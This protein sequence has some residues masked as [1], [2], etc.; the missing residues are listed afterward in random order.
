MPSTS[1]DDWPDSLANHPIIDAINSGALGGV[2][3]S[4][5]HKC[6]Q[7]MVQRQTDLFI[8][9]GSQLRVASLA[10]NFKGHHL[11][12]IIAEALD[13][14]IH[15]LVL[16]PTGNL[17]AVA[18]EYQVALVALPHAATGDASPKDLECQSFQ[19]GAHYHASKV[20]KPI[21]QVSWHP[22]GYEGST[23]LVMTSD[24]S[25]REYNVSDD[26]TTPSQQISF[27]PR[28][29]FAGDEEDRE[30]VSFTIGKSRADWAPLTLY[31]VTRLGDIYSICPYLPQRASV[32]PSYIHSLDSFVFEKREV[33]SRGTSTAAKKLATMYEHQSAYV[34]GLLEQ[35]PRGSKSPSF[36][37]KETVLV[38]PPQNLKKQNPTRQGPFILRPFPSGLEH[39][40]IVNEVTDMT[41]LSLGG[42][43]L[44]EDGEDQFEAENLG[45]LLLAYKDG[46]VDLCLDVDKIEARWEVNSSLRETPM[47]LVY[48][49]IDLGLI[50]KLEGLDSAF[51]SQLE[52]NYPSFYH[53]PIHDGTV[54][55]YHALGVH[56]LDAWPLLDHLRRAL[57][58]NDEATAPIEFETCLRT[59]PPTD[60]VPI[61]TTFSVEKKSSS[62]V[63][64]LAI[65]DD[66][67]LPYSAI[68][69]TSEM[70]VSCFPL[71]LRTDYTT[72]GFPSSSSDDATQALTSATGALTLS[73][74]APEKRRKWLLPIPNQPPPYVSLL[75]N[76]PWNSPAVLD[77]PLPD[78]P[79]ASSNSKQRDAMLTPESLRYL[80]KTVSALQSQIYQVQVAH[81]KTQ[82]RAELQKQEVVRA[83]TKAKEMID[84]VE[85]LKGPSRDHINARHA[86]VLAMQRT[87]LD[88]TEKM[89]HSIMKAVAPELTADEKEWFE[90][91]GNL[92]KE[93]EGKGVFDPEGL[94]HRTRILDAEFHRIIPMMT[95]AKLKEAKEVSEGEK[96]GFKEAFE[97]GK[98]SEEKRVAIEK[99]EK[100]TK[101]VAQKV[102][103][104]WTPWYPITERD[105]EEFKS[106]S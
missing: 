75:A 3:L 71:F 48:E 33:L 18:G 6:Q 26:H 69:L 27:F 25:L 52:R 44:E 38:Q 58:Q 61:L 78:L 35:L 99:L 105:R 12:T 9:S 5:S 60:V 40:T 51:I 31:A 62:P 102:D 10:S 57:K 92:R 104:L 39:S 13:F 54:F 90:E 59:C 37:L 87:L 96:L 15:H 93:V 47:L 94:A 63:I 67:Y 21:A 101:E 86:K 72:P 43:I 1:S 29:F 89:L 14:E 74:S 49:S 22:W 91:L 2:N 81:R 28:S 17:L 70:R 79:L 73:T 55:V 88:R 97:F 34:A 46:R 83:A 56:S 45:V 19:V 64:G 8:A 65:T 53:D 68:I 103:A 36:S 100:L 50:S 77:D 23:L 98:Q 76:L 16:N 42:H 32:P 66:I 85:R 7:T 24:G 41:Y 20:G 95:Q 30:I 82:Q 11:R 80:G 106:D 84:K 4:G